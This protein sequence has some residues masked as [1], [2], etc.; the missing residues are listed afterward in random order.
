MSD[1]E[2]VQLSG[3][4]AFVKICCY[5]KFNVSQLS[6]EEEMGD[7]PE[8]WNMRLTLCDSKLNNGM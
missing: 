8:K 1:K 4:L 7:L 2:N 3:N 6:R 5:S